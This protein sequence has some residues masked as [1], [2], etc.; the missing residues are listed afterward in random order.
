MKAFPIEQY[1]KYVSI[2]ILVIIIVLSY[3]II[4]PFLHA[5][6]G[7]IVLAYIFNPLYKL[8]NKRIKKPT[9]SALLVILILVLIIAIPLFLIINSLVKETIELNKF[10]K[11]S[12]LYSEILNIKY[13]PLIIEKTSQYIINNASNIII[14]LPTFFLNVFIA[15]FTLFYLLTQGESFL[16]NISDRI[17]LEEHQKKHL[18]DKFIET[19]RSLIF[20]LV[21]TGV[22]QG[23]LIALSFYIFGVG[24][25]I[26]FG[27]I[28]LVLAIIPAIGPG[29]VW[30]PASAIKILTGN[31]SDGIGILAV[32][33]L[34]VTPIEIILRPKL[35]E[36]KSSLHPIAILLGV[37]GG[38]KFMGFIGMIY[39]PLILS[40]AITLI[41]FIEETKNIKITV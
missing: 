10:I 29:I 22:L 28:V 15:L 25:P 39:G 13:V 3:F 37:I 11:S 34:L 6:L 1:N 16:K 5:I 41:K 33:L 7:S 40:V 36:K 32:G 30:V 35:I 24:S 31:L 17:P 21:V 12:D 23:I 27:S 2:A 19:V 4:K 8:A 9:I 18:I 14:S 26:L 20:G 38:V